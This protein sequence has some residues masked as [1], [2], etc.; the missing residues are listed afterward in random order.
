[1]LERSRRS[2]TS[3]AWTCALR[4]MTLIACGTRCAG[5]PPVAR[6]R[7]QPST[8][9]S[10]VRS[11]CESA[12]RNSSFIRFASES[13]CSADF[14]ERDVHR[15]AVEAR[16]M[17]VLIVKA[18]PE[19]LEPAY[20]PVGVQHAVIHI[21]ARMAE[22]RPF[23]LGLHAL[24]VVGVHAL[25]E[26]IQR[27]FGVGRKTVVRLALRV[28]IHLLG[29][30]VAIPVSDADGVH[31]FGET[32]V[33]EL[34]LLQLELLASTAVGKGT[35]DGAD[36]GKDDQARKRDGRVRLVSAEDRPGDRDTADDG[37]V[38]LP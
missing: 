8:A 21:A 16:R 29:R 13:V 24:T 36:H 27:D 25:E 30:Q 31:D 5:K 18:A 9:L 32:G 14:C 10:G 38:P 26:Q 2:S 34:Q 37:R 22:Y 33:L 4:S 23:I 6:S 11:S 1:M 17:A 19:R 28:P 7:A 12:P 3:R 15:D 35:D 20:L